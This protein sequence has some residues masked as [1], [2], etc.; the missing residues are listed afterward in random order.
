[1]G[2]PVASPHP[3][4]FP[5]VWMGDGYLGIIFVYLLKKEVSTLASFT[6]RVKGLYE[7][8]DG[9]SSSFKCL[10]PEV[11]YK[12]TILCKYCRLQTTHVIS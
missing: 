1:M 7:H 2:T 10:K 12:F 3:R 5:S 9:L 6:I 11:T 4:P 8:K